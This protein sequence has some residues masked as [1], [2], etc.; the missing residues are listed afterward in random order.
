MVSCQSIIKMYPINQ[1]AAQKNLYVSS[2]NWTFDYYHITFKLK[3]ALMDKKENSWTDM[4]RYDWKNVPLH[5]NTLHK[6]FANQIF[7]Q[8]KKT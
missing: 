1:K 7:M 8:K 6:C 3:I 2:R 5:P 4:I